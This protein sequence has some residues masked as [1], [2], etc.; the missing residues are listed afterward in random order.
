MKVEFAN[1]DL[2]RICTNEAHRMGLPIAVIKA[3]R[4]RLI[5]MEAA[6]DERDLRNLRGLHYKKLQGSREGQHAIRVNDQYRIVFTMSGGGR[7]AVITVIE[8]GDTH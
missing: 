2:A 4:R 8:I 3:A 1:G 7:T 5:Q 6:L